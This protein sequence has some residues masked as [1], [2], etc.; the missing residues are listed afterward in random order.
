MEVHH[1]A[2]TAAGETMMT[3]VP[4]A[5]EAE[6]TTT[7]EDQLEIET[8]HLRGEARAGEIMVENAG[9]AGAEVQID[10]IIETALLTGI[11]IA[12]DL[13]LGMIETGIQEVRKV[14]L[15]N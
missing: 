13:G 7:I 10:E 6:E 11:G 15:P 5:A 2:V 8:S 3:A 9:E 1:P 14:I 12:T 4:V